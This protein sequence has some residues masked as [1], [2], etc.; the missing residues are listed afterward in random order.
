MSS[1]SAEAARPNPVIRFCK[2]IWAD[3]SIVVVCVVFFIAFGVIQPRFMTVPNLLLIMRQS[4]VV[5]M[6]A[7]GMTFVIITG[8]IDLSC[9]H[10][11]AASGAVLITMQANE[12][13]PMP[14]AILACMAVATAIG[15]FN[16]VLITRFNLPAFIVT[17]AIGIMARSLTKYALS[18]AT[19][20]GRNIPQFT[21]IGLGTI[22][23]IPNA[24]IIWLLS[25]VVLGC[26]LSYTK[27]GSYIYAVGGNESA[28][29]YSGISVNKIKVLAYTLTGFCVSIATVLDLSR[30][31]AISPA[32]AGDMYE[33]DAITAVVV[34]GT[35]LAGGR[36]RILGT[37]FGVIMITVVSNVMVMMRIS[38]YL[39]GAV[40]GL[41][42][43]AA[44]LLQRQDR[45][46]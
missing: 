23:I 26:V 31:A 45:A 18:G 21:Q 6:I 32:T 9:G 2:L 36:G 12:A 4:S 20:A 35:S 41:I 33:F 43:L 5:G 44:V 14:F 7:L 25:T 34:G 8:G 16:G 37:V 17:L 29:K 46:A 10:V 24:L 42:I 11:L 1:P 39:S 15:L 22:G 3:Y 38:P 19:V 27:F 13:I 28:A 30:M 40:K